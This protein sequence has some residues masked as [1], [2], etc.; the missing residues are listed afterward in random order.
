MACDVLL[1]SNTYRR[2]CDNNGF[3]SECGNY[4][5]SAEVAY[6]YIMNKTDFIESH[7]GLEDVMIEIDIMAKCYKRKK[8]MTTVINPACWMRVQR[9]R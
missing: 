1:N 2:F 8:K 7:T 3:K 4:K 6:N 9:K 5:T